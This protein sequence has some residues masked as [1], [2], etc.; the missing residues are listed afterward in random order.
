MPFWGLWNQTRHNHGILANVYREQD[1]KEITPILPEVIL[2][3]L[4][5]NAKLLENMQHPI[6]I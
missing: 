6:D 1:L 3:S 2:A 5:V 4:R